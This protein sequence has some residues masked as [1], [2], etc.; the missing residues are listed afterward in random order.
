MQ[1]ASILEHFFSVYFAFVFCVLYD[2]SIL[3][4]LSQADTRSLKLDAWRQL[5]SEEGMFAADI[6]NMLL[7]SRIQHIQ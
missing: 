3:L 2:M 6:R 7:L 4:F 1:L 5:A